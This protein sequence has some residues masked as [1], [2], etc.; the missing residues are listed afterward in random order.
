MQGHSLCWAFWLSSTDVEY[1]LRPRDRLALK[2]SP[3]RARVPTSQSTP[4][5]HHHAGG[6]GCGYLRGPLSFAS[7]LPIATGLSLFP[8]LSPHGTPLPAPPAGRSGLPPTHHHGSGQAGGVGGER[9]GRHL[10]RRCAGPGADVGAAVRR[11][12]PDRALAGAP[13]SKNGAPAALLFSCRPS[14]SAP[15][16]GAKA[17]EGGRLAEADW[18]TGS[19]AGRQG[20]SMVACA[21]Y[22]RDFFPRVFRCMSVR[23]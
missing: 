5:Q 15:A 8:P 9:P 21:D 2:A 17:F 23:A 12:R 6:R 20:W 4:C 16:V 18:R 3:R 1:S 14:F 10:H 13:K 19:W 22:E 7:L 11:R